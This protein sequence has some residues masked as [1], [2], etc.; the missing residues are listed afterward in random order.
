[1]R[2]DATTVAEYRHGMPL[3][4]PAARKAYQAAYRAV[5]LERR[6]AL[7]ALRRSVPVDVAESAEAAC[8]EVRR[9]EALQMYL[10]IIRESQ[11]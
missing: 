1:M 11:R 9:A 5:D 3:K 7:V 10:A 6:A 8:R 4:D 2:H